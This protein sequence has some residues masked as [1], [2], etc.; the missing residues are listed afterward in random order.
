MAKYR[1][2]KAK[3]SRRFGAPIL[4]CE[5]V[6]KRK[7]YGPGMHGKKSKRKSEYALQLTEKQKTKYTY[8]VLEKQFRNL[9]QKASKQK[10]IASEILV[11]MLAM[12]IDNVVCC[13]GI[14]PTNAGARQLVVHRHIK[15]NGHTFDRPSY[16]LKEGDT[17]S[18]SEKA[19]QFIVVQNSLANNKKKYP[20]LA[21]D[22]E[23]MTG[24]IIAIPN[25]QDIPGNINGKMIIEFYA[26]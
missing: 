2:P 9:V 20:W 8:G 7:N 26:R 12:R 18:L 23:N 22:K 16:T 17:I 13:L 14:S 1:G 5:K 11:Q 19:K 6:L 3:I 4:G 15:L 25:K 21:W 24:K 10:G